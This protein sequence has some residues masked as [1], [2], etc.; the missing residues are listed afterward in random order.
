MTGRDLF[1]DT[2]A[3]AAAAHNGQDDEA[4]LPYLMHPI[5]VAKLVDVILERFEAHHLVA[6]DQ[7]HQAALLHDVL[8][9]TTLTVEDLLDAGLSTNVING[10][11]A[12]TKRV[13]EEYH[14][15]I[16]RICDA[17]P[18][19]VLLKLADIEHNLKVRSKDGMSPERRARLASKYTAA[20]TRLVTALGRYQNEEG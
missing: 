5:G 10:V 19:A 14:E 8:E 13:G 16:D 15:F 20:R 4:G 18:F 17:G 1:Y 3:L 2:L 6:Q 12:V 11:R 9:D 7:L